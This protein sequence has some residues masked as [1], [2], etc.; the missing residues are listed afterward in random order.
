MLV[1]KKLTLQSKAQDVVAPNDKMKKHRDELESIAGELTQTM[2]ETQEHELEG[3]TAD[4][5]TAKI[6]EDVDKCVSTYT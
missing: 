6:Y 5:A 4:D 2:W 1:E 3:A